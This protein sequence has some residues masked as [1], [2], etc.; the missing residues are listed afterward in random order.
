MACRAP[1]TS[2]A[3]C[4][5][6]PRQRPRR[7]T[8]CIRPLVSARCSHAQVGTRGRP[9]WRR[10]LACTTSHMRITNS[11]GE[12]LA[13]RQSD[14]ASTMTFTQ[15]GTQV[16]VTEDLTNAYP[17]HHNQILNWTRTLDFNT[18]VLTVHDVCQVASGVR[19]T[20]QLNVP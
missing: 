2:R 19:P 10:W 3:I 14:T 9:G 16:T 20:F 18:G 13:Q 15:S 12:T 8:S 5:R 6:M 7:R 1:S 4:C 11:Q 17:D